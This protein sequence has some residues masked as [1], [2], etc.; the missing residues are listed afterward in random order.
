MK[1]KNDE[2]EK[3]EKS[4]TRRNE[5][6][7]KKKNQKRRNEEV[8]ILH[9]VGN[10]PG[11]QTPRSQGPT[12]FEEMQKIKKKNKKKTRKIA[13]NKEKTRKKNPKQRNE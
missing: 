8:Q 2:R 1:S 7:K 6:E 10:P 5:E 12:L 4:Q 13:Q 11:Q 9:D 3:K